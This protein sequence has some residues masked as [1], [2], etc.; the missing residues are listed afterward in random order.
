MTTRANA[1][2]T[3]GTAGAAGIPIPK[4][5][6][7]PLGFRRSKKYPNKW[8]KKTQH[9]TCFIV[10]FRKCSSLNV[11]KINYTGQFHIITV[12]CI[13]PKSWNQ[14]YT[15]PKTTSRWLNKSNLK[16]MLVKLIQI[17]SFPQGGVKMKNI[18]NHP[19]ATNEYPQEKGAISKG[20]LIG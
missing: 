14:N 16:H 13:T 4:P 9:T 19:P 1:R 12:N 20:N 3:P 2:S 7:L 8:P 6:D 11:S 15:L 17:G 10:G 18:W 5:S